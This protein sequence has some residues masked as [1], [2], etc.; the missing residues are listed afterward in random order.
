MYQKV[1]ELYKVMNGLLAIFYE[2]M[3]LYSN[4]KQAL[5]KSVQIASNRLKFCRINKWKQQRNELNITSYQ[6]ITMATEMTQNLNN[7]KI[8]AQIANIPLNIIG[9]NKRFINYSTKIEEYYNYLNESLNNQSIHENDVLILLDAYDVLIFPSIRKLATKL[10]TSSTPIVFC[11][12]R[13]IYPELIGP[14]MYPKSDNNEMPDLSQTRYLNSGC[15]IGRAKQLYEMYQYVY[16]NRLI[17]NDDQQIMIR[18][19]IENPDMI[20]LDIHHEYFM[21][22]YR[23]FHNSQKIII[24]S[25]F[26]A[27]FIQ[28]KNNINNIIIKDISIIHFNNIKSYE[29]IYFDIMNQIYYYINHY[30]T[31]NDGLGLLQCIQA[32]KDENYELAKYIL[33]IDFIQSNRS[34]RGGTNSLGDYLLSKLMNMSTVE[35]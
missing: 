8:C 26:Q 18:Y 30:Y 15:I 24:E 35:L 7:L 11:S 32:M 28:S 4:M 23:Q 10:M 6:I 5:F 12:E 31:G 22:G 3:S 17:Y 33:E 25:D 21:T 9:L 19:Y 16:T 34:S 2:Q 29:S 14:L 1:N 27:N 13:G 20:S